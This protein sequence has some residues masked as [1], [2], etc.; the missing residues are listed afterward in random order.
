MAA[1]DTAGLHPHQD[2][3]GANRGY[4]PLLQPHILIAVIDSN[5]HAEALTAF[6]FSFLNMS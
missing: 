3:T 4:G 2:L 1:A 5:P 6:S